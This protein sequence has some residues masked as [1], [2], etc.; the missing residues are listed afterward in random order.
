M[1]G[2]MRFTRRLFA[3]LWA[4]VLLSTGAFSSCADDEEYTETTEVTFE[5]DSVAGD[6]DQEE[7]ASREGGEEI[8]EEEKGCRT[9]ESKGDTDI[10]DEKIQEKAEPSEKAD[11]SNKQNAPTEITDAEDDDDIKLFPESGV[12][13]ALKDEFLQNA[14][15]Q[16]EEFQAS[17]DQKRVEETIDSESEK[18]EIETYPDEK[19][20]KHAEN[21]QQDK[22]TEEQEDAVLF[23]TNSRSDEVLPM[24]GILSV[25]KGIDDI[26]EDTEEK[27]EEEESQLQK[28]T[29]RDSEGNKDYTIAVSFPTKKTFANGYQVLAVVN[30][31]SYKTSITKNMDPVYFNGT[32]QFPDKPEKI[33]I[34][35]DINRVF[36]EI[37]T[38]GGS[39]FIISEPIFDETNHKC[40][41]SGYERKACR[42]YFEPASGTEMPDT[43]YIVAKRKGSGIAVAYAEIKNGKITKDEGTLYN[44]TAFVIVKADSFSLGTYNGSPGSYKECITKSGD[45][46][47]NKITFTW[48][49]EAKLSGNSYIYSVCAEQKKDIVTEETY[50]YGTITITNIDQDG[51]ELDGSSFKL[52]AEASCSK[53]INTYMGRSFTISTKEDPVDYLPT[54]TGTDHARTLY[55]KQ[56]E[57][58]AGYDIDENIH[59]VVITKTITEQLDETENKKTIT[60]SYGITIDEANAVNIVNQKRMGEEDRKDGSIAVTVTDSNGAELSGSTCKLF[61]EE[62]C[63]NAIKTYTGGSITISTADASLENYLP[64]GT[65]PNS[66]VTLYLQETAAQAGYEADTTVYPVVITKNVAENLNT[67]TNEFIITTTYGIRIG[68]VNAVNIVNQKRMGE[69]DRKDGS[70]AVTVTDSNGAEL[71]GSTCKL[72]VEENC[73]NAI[74]TYTGGSITISTADISLEKYLPKG[75]EPDTSVTLYLKETVAQ[76]GYNV[77]TTVHPVVITK[78]VAESLNTDANEF[79]I[80]TT[81]GITIDGGNAVNIAN[82]KRMGEEARKDGSIAVTVTDSNGAELSGS[83]CKLFAE[84]SCTNPIKTYTG[85]SITISTADI[86]LEKYLPKGTEP[87]S[88]VTLYLKET[89]AQAGYNVNTTIHPVVITKSV[90]E[91]L[92]TDVNEFIIT[93]TYG[94]TIDEAIAVNIENQ[95]RMGKEKREDGSV[96]VTVTDSNGAELS[97][98]TCNL[99][100]ED[101]CKTEIKKYPGKSFTISTA[102]ISLNDYL[103][104]GT[105]PETS[106]T[107]YLKET[108]AQAGYNVNTTV[109][110]VVIIKSVAESLNI[111]T[112]EFITTTT[113]GITIDGGNAVNIA[114]QKRMGEE[115]RKD[116]SIAVTVT[117]SN[118]AELSGST[119]KLFAE[120]SCTNPIKTYTGGSI[121]I[122]TADT[123]LENYLPKGT[124]PDTSVTLYLKETVAQ[125]GYEADITVYP[126]VITKNVAEN[127]NTKTNEF[128]ITTTYGI[129]I[130]GKNSVTIKNTKNTDT[131]RV[132]G[133][134]EVTVTDSDG[135]EL[136]G[137][138]CNLYT[139]EN[140]KTGIR[141]C[142]GGKFT[143]STA[144]TLLEK[145][146]PKGTEPDT[147]VTL[148]LKETTAQAG[149]EADI[150]V[151]PVVITKNVSENLDTSINVFITT[152]TYGITIDGKNSVTIKNT[153]NTDTKREDGSIAIANKD[154]DGVALCGSTF[155]LYPNQECAEES[156]LVTYT[157]QSFVI[158]TSDEALK[159]SLPAA[160]GVENATTLYLKQETA[161]TDYDMDPELHSVVITKEAETTYLDTENNMYIT[162]TVYGI[163]ID[164]ESEVV[165]TN[166]RHSVTNGEGNHMNP[167]GESNPTGEGNGDSTTTEGNGN[168]TVGGE[169]NGTTAWGDENNPT[170]EG[171]G[172]S[173]IT[174]GNGNTT[175]GGEGNGTT[176]GGNGNNTTGE[177][178]GGSTITEENGNVTN[179]S[180]DDGTNTGDSG[181]TVTGEVNGKSA[182]SGETVNNVTGGK[183]ENSKN[184]SENGD[185]TVTG[186]SVSV[187]AQER[188]NDNPNS[189]SNQDE[190]APGTA[191]INTNSGSITVGND[192]ATKPTAQGETA[193]QN[194]G[195]ETKPLITKTRPWSQALNT[196]KN[197]APD[198]QNEDIII[199]GVGIEQVVSLI[200]EAI[201]IITRIVE[202][203]YALARNNI[204]AFLK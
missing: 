188:N 69:E 72:F 192:E 100:A 139:E 152:T 74:K 50:E 172:G 97:G 95:K 124:E 174:E 37:D 103:P 200:Q 14:L 28:G 3:I 195:T 46:F 163:A 137:S 16:A 25:T 67:E 162:K 71:S 145:Y 87:N 177:D 58:Q 180:D 193:V 169:G 160:T 114:N 101:S 15:G 119:C 141:M 158:S 125:A 178:N 10:E 165:I 155:K 129:T 153:K 29:L 122:N 170:G 104:K 4:L 110:P 54:E 11:L 148:Y 34:V 136:N 35:D 52:Y 190:K 30:G 22:E 78:S 126:V 134:V 92:N 115:A 197:K 151:Y 56:T 81:Y 48:D 90:V 106:V 117:D 17:D 13:I 59:R 12:E 38:D 84:E 24:R 161:P 85:G 99:Y 79:I 166:N 75:T 147:S 154:S 191:A 55:L 88:S 6:L 80:T 183:D 43:Y 94:I 61:V 53:E 203:L 108:A 51:A 41:L 127:L 116:G 40:T 60:T 181:E 1:E 130:G 27:N 18:D 202:L 57:A 42:I 156:E 113:Y 45:S 149:Y 121:T 187:T 204:F 168:T 157:D 164:G 176:T 199:Q 144:D 33:A 107:L 184:S 109:H 128:I 138:I 98:S 2:R 9:D 201:R 159:N 132:N 32:Y 198:E 120:E 26:H 20:N 105:E 23:E 171:N 82:Q 123:S 44:D 118:G 186:S 68:E 91:S 189:Q 49:N 65:E 133:N 96:V 167:E 150:T 93:T 143:I 19:E 196:N 89:E 70:I 86:S 131:K 194:D 64:K 185:E 31:V 8:P 73:T 66:S 83:T 76:A 7:E 112:N 173:M 146:L 39:S 142:P 111:E 36:Y 77:N 62:N 140:C 21:A 5:T 47:N 179:G 182:T 135:A 63:T 175:I 102:D